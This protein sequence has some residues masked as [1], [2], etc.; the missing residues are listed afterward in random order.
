MSWRVGHSLGRTLYRDEVLVGMVDTAELAA[1]IVN[2]MNGAEPEK[3][4]TSAI[5]DVERLTRHSGLKA[6]VTITASTLG[7]PPRRRGL[8]P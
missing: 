3:T 7:P 6:R 4:L 2:A 5:Q 8:K 1:E